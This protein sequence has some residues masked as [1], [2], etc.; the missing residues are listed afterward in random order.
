MLD[1]EWNANDQNKTDDGHQQV[2][3]RKPQSGDQKPDDISKHAQHAGA[4]TKL[5]QLGSRD[6]FPAKR[7]ERKLPDDK[8]GP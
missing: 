4:D 6:G 1:A 7:K 5:L 8:A 2:P 3:E